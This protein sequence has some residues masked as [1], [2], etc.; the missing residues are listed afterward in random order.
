[1]RGS[2]KK[3]SF[4][5]LLMRFFLLL[6]CTFFTFIACLPCLLSTVWGR[7]KLTL[8]INHSIPGK[9]AID[10]LS[11]AWFGPQSIR[12]LSLSDQQNA[13]ILSLDVA[14]T[15][16]SLF[17]LILYPFA[18]NSFKL[19]GLSA[20]LIGENEKDTNFLRALTNTYTHP[21]N[22]STNDRAPFVIALRNTEGHLNLSKKTG[23][24]TLHLNGETQQ[25]L[26]QGTFLIDAELQGINLKELVASGNDFAALLHSRPD[27]EL[28]IHVDIANFPLELIN[29]VTLLKSPQCS[30]AL[31]EL[32]GNELNLKIDQKA[33]ANGISLQVAADSSSLVA[34]TDILIDNE[35]TLAS[36]AE[37][38]LKISPPLFDKFFEL[39][40]IETPWRLSSTSTVA[41]SITH[42][43]L[44]L[45][46]L[47]ANQMGIDSFELTGAVEVAETHFIE[48][49]EN[50][51][52]VLK[53]LLATLATETDSQTV[54]I[55][56]ACEADLDKHPGKLN[57]DLSLPKKIMFSDFSEI[58]LSDLV[59]HGDVVGAPLFMLDGLANLP[60]L[61]SDMIGPHADLSFSLQR[62]GAKQLAT[63]QFESDFLA[64]PRLVFEVDHQITLEKPTQFIL[65]INH[66]R[67]NEILQGFGPQMQGLVTAQLTLNSFS[68]PLSPLSSSL[69][70]IP[71]INLDAQLNVNSIRLA[72]VPRVGG[73]SL[74]DF[75]MNLAC[76]KKT[77]P[78]LMTS[79]SLQPD[80]QSALSDLIG[81]KASFKTSLSLEMGADDTSFANV[82]NMHILTDLA[83]LELS[84]EIQE[85]K[86]LI[87]NSPALLTYTLTKRGLEA[88]GFA[89]DSYLFKHGTPLEMTIDSPHIPLNL[90][91]LSLLKLT[92][93][94]KFE[95]FQLMQE[96]SKNTLLAS[97]D[98][99]SASWSID[100][101][102]QL[103]AVDF[104]GGTRLGDH[105]AAA[106]Y[107]GG[108]IA[109]TKWIKN[110][111]FDLN[112]AGLHLDASAS[113]LPMELISVLSQEKDLQLLFGTALDLSI[114]VNTSLDKLEKG[115]LSID[116]KSE[117]LS[118]GLGLSLGEM[119]E[120]NASR[121][122]EF[123]LKLTPEG[124]TALRHRFKEI[125][126][127]D[128]ALTEPTVATLKL[129]SLRFPRS[130]SYLQ[131][132]IEGKFSVGHLSGREPQT[133]NKMTLNALEGDFS[134]HNL[135]EKIDFKIETKSPMKQAH[136]TLLNIN[137]S[138]TNGFLP[139]GSINK[140]NLLIVLDASVDAL[141]IRLFCQFICL[142]S[143]LKQQVQALLGPTVNAKIKA[144]LHHLSGALFI[145]VQGDNGRF[146]LDAN[147]EKG[148]MT[149][150]RDLKAQLTA[151][152]E[153]GEYVIDDLLPVLSGM[154]SA[155]QPITLTI[156][157][158]AFS[159]FLEKPLSKHLR[160]GKAILNMGK[161]HFSTESQ[162]AKVLSL[163][164]S[165]ATNQLVWLTPAYFSLNQGFLKLERVDML[166]NDRYP[167]ATWGDVDISKDRV[168]MV[169][170]LTGSAISKAF[171]VPEI[172]NSYMLQLPL[173]GKLNSPSIDKAK[174]IARLSALVAHSQGGPQG[175]V[176]GTVLDIATGGLTEHPI[177][178]PTTEPLPWSGLMRDDLAPAPS[179]R[180]SKVKPSV[181]EEI[182]KGASSV[183]KKIFN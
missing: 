91:D 114:E 127:N 53:R 92:G 16:H 23:S 166:I 54:E 75:S 118:G 6:L 123:S 156:E 158:E 171:N 149:L 35:V 59:F 147:L 140:E 1:M 72:N 113:Q 48:S 107:I 180:D 165:A 14:A 116:I 86:R 128:F 103:L 145:D 157:K 137:G 146:A 177:P 85:G 169:I 172:S 61:P 2:P 117:N 153:L 122:A 143:K 44:P 83:R 183:L 134:S 109:V 102:N 68:M 50:G 73:V 101:P 119:V 87:L 11:L 115:I 18:I 4:L 79:F 94:L 179:S 154:V 17:S 3:S 78:E 7:D 66:N 104:K 170:G 89:V 167:I 9:V 46:A 41:L 163:L 29:Q 159:L 56:V 5:K 175:L 69:E 36:P 96:V 81:K 58:L 77:P 22:D 168:N 110:G 71:Q 126:A 152:R 181:I 39:A 95:D 74:N 164:T 63:L 25:N 155:D 136:P 105:Q 65:K 49:K 120:L 55:T 13:T 62:Q 51:E 10:D 125:K 19:K 70:M 141:P 144:N 139:D 52:L 88:M 112:H 131:A 135:S 30:G 124:Y 132:G 182:G 151:T 42:L 160:I 129:H 21:K 64:I 138:L 76:N 33:T 130:Q 161:V 99:F 121:S 133:A 173:K 47:D 174:A 93:R 100:A 45:T 178:P 40:E 108:S 31:T 15:D 97:I 34:R 80:G 8:A 176:L 43:R 26:R 38:T 27:A 162:I 98:T 150:N 57:F 24:L 142:D 106:G 20:T 90:N 32:F 111:S 148:M 12:G 60:L 84:G 67:I 28:N 37:L 82:F